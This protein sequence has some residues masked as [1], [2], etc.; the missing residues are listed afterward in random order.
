MVRFKKLQAVDAWILISI[1]RRLG[2]RAWS[3]KQDQG[4]GFAVGGG[5]RIGVPEISCVLVVFMRLLCQC[6]QNQPASQQK[7]V[8]GMP[9]SSNSSRRI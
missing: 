6:V 8:A 3:G 7:I 2:I 1:T 9:G 4:G 5:E